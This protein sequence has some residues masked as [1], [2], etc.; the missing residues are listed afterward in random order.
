MFA[1]VC[2]INKE[3]GLV[4]VNINGRVTNWLPCVLS[5]PSIGQQVAIVEFENDGTGFVIGSLSRIDGNPIDIHIGNID[6]WCDGLKTKIKS[7]VEITG[8]VVIRGKLEVDKEIKTHKKVF[9][10]RG[11]LS[12]FVTTDGSKR[13]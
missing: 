9:D 5:T 7:P 10:S 12:D 6:I 1:T 8:D 11:D 2:E 13:A 3:K 4:K